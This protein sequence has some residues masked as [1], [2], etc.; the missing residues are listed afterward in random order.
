M[1][2]LPGSRWLSTGTGIREEVWAQLSQ[3][4]VV[5]THTTNEQP[6][7]CPIIRSLILVTLSFLKQNIGEIAP[8]SGSKDKDSSSTSG[9]EKQ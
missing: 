7:V 5:D 3:G 1:V 9:P 2:R 6:G 8:R 4:Q